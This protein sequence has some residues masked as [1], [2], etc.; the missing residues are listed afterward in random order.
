MRL[1]QILGAAAAV[2]LLGNVSHIRAAGTLADTNIL[3]T[4]TVDFTVGGLAQAPINSNTTNFETDRRV[5]VTVSEFGGAYTDVTPG[6]TGQVLRFSVLNNTNDTMDFRLDVAQDALGVADPY[7]G[8]DDFDPTSSVAYVDN[9]DDVYVAL[10]DTETH[11]DELAPDTSVTVWIVS[12]IPNSLVDQDTAGLTLTAIAAAAGTGGTLGGDY[13]QSANDDP[14]AVDTVFGDAA[15]DTDN[16]RD[17]RHSAGDAYRALSATIT[18][19]KTTTVVSDP[20][21]LGVNPKRIPGAVIE[22]CI[23][24]SNT[25][26]S[27]ATAVVISDDLAGQPVTYEPGTLIAGGAADCTGG[28]AEDDDDAGADEL[29]TGA[30]FTGT[31][32]EFRVDTLGSGSTTSFRFQVRIVN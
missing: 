9:G 29:G 2:V 20:F 6:Q 21:N 17:G 18:V 4:A 13:T 30:N 26:G 16:A 14:N 7:G 27:D 32:A 28:T 10:D 12:S 1:K 19:A 22:Y 11:V 5:L 24:V 3:N 8:F 15:G 31:V 23:V 25:G